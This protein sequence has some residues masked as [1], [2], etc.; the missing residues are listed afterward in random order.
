M[1]NI[2]PPLTGIEEAPKSLI[3]NYDLHLE[4]IYSTIAKEKLW[5]DFNKSGA[6]VKVSMAHMRPRARSPFSLLALETTT[7]P[8]EK[9]SRRVVKAHWSFHIAFV[10]HP[11][12][13]KSLVTGGDPV[14]SFREVASS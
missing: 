9:S 10:V 6:G 4:F 5:C 3:V 7:L 11:E 8:Q 12:N 1:F 2:R 13:T 14:A